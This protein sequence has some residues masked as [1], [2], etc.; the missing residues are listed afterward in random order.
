MEKTAK[1]SLN[2]P[3]TSPV[4]PQVYDLFLP[5]GAG[6]S[7]GFGAAGKGE[8]PTNWPTAFFSFPEELLRAL[9]LTGAALR[10]VVAPATWQELEAC[11]KE[12]LRTWSKGSIPFDGAL[13]QHPQAHQCEVCLSVIPV[14]LRGQYTFQVFQKCSGR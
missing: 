6:G 13:H 1:T 9:R 3:S 7:I 8:A 10:A 2:V 5:V 14:P 4:P 11:R 12:T